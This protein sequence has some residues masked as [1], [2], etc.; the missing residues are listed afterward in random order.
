M[1][2]FEKLLNFST[3]HRLTAHIIFWTF[4][5]IMFFSKN[6]SSEPEE[7]RVDILYTLYYEVFSM[8]S[9]YFLAY[10][11]LPRLMAPQ[12][13]MWVWIEFV[14]V[15]Y[16]IS[17][18]AR[19]AMVYGLEPFVRKEPF[20][21]ESIVEI[22]TDL[23]TLFGSYLLHIF[24][25]S[26]FFVFIKLIKDQY[27]I[28]KRSLLLE[29]QKAETELKILKAQLNPHF[30]FNTLNNIY[31]LSIINSPITS[32]SI[33]VLSEIL[34][35]ILYRCGSTYVPISQEITL[36]DNY[37]ALEKLRYDERLSVIFN[38][39]VENNGEIAPLILLSLVENAFKHGAGEDTGVS[40]IIE[41]DLKLIENS[42]EFIIKNSINQ[43]D[44]QAESGKIGLNNII[45]QLDKI[46][47]DHYTFDI[48]KTEKDFTA[49]LKINL[50]T[51][52]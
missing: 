48:I 34:D 3:A 39:T 49:H 27:I 40:P 12:K 11:I 20:T 18:I 38:H 50:Q 4:I 46:Y 1:T 17:I 10:R 19:I 43:F 7:L 14:V 31:S 30:L 37:I 28:Q 52:N 13:H 23:P 47:P 29:K 35:C 42:F 15:S 45:Q 9:A 24:S 6:T 32:K 44:N 51:N 5:F 25:L 2:P 16:L 21:Q 22:L 33:A 8:L 41:I 36:I 26:M